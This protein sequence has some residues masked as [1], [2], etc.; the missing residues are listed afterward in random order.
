[1][2][3]VCDTHGHTRCGLQTDRGRGRIPTGHSWIY[4]IHLDRWPI[5]STEWCQ[6]CRPTQTTL[7]VD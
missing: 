7:E 4:A 1:M 3:H 5:D 6:T 2:T